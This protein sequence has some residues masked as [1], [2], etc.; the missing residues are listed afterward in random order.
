MADSILQTERECFLTGAVDGLHRHHI[1][2]G[3]RRPASEKWGCWVYLRWDLH[4]GSDYCVHKDKKLELQLQQQCQER[5]EE[6]YG[7]EKFMKVF[8][9]N[10]REDIDA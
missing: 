4:N 1:F 5:F 9:K 6:L 3:P 7:H 10:Y 2:R 8:G